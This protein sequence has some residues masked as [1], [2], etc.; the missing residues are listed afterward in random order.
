MPMGACVSTPESKANKIIEE[1][2]REDRKRM[3]AEVKILLLGPGESGKS[4]V[5]K[6]MK[7]IQQNGGYSTEELLEYKYII[8]GNCISQM[9]CLVEA[10]KKLNLEPAQ[11]NKI[12]F[13][14]MAKIP[15]GGDSWS[16]EVATDIRNLWRDKVIRSVYE[17]RDRDF[18]LNDSAAY[19]FNEIERFMNPSFVPTQDDVLRARIRTTGIQ[20]AEFKF[21]ELG[22]R[23]LDV[24]GQR[25]ERRKW[26]HCFDSVTAV[27]FC[28]ALSEYDQMLRED[29]TQNR[30]KESLLLFDEV[31]NS[32]WFKKTSFI[33]FLNKVDLFREKVAK[34]DLSVCFPSYT[35]GLNFEKGS[36]FIKAQ[37]EERNKSG[38]PVYTHFTCAI[39]TENIEF[40]F[41]AVREVILEEAIQQIV[42]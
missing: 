27:I 20:E 12:G 13:E 17:R 42:V 24:G 31:C 35:G 25:S 16:I 11:A 9:R 37:F 10:A 3:K 1:K 28:V 5:F 7:I 38:D 40:V 29:V 26:I 8:F 2:L 41:Q 23:M 33:L 19:F 14:R 22:F 30:M 4:T 6:Q 32:H 18:Q 39:S 21:D 15:P 34:V 36:E